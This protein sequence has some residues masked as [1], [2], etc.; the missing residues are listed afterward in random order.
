MCTLQ[1]FTIN[2]NTDWKLFTTDNSRLDK[3]WLGLGRGISE[4]IKL[5]NIILMCI[6]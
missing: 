6:I 3:A 4:L 2:T 1:L 5:N